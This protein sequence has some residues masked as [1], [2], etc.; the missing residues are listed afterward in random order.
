LLKLHKTLPVKWIP[1]NWSWEL[2]QNNPWI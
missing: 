1:L 2:K